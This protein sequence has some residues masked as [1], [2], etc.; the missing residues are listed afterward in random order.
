MQSESSQSEGL[1]D[2]RPD[3]QA[4]NSAPA[5]LLN[6]LRQPVKPRH[7][8]DSSFQYPRPSALHG[9]PRQ[10]VTQRQP[11]PLVGYSD[12]K[13]IGKTHPQEKGREPS[14]SKGLDC[15]FCVISVS[16]TL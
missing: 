11:D 1:P 14:S 2:S 13:A 16:W 9:P 4:Q 15:D 3:Y 8:S 10:E 12:N 7:K 5:A 6:S